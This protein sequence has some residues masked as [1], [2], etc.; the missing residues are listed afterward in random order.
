VRV[1]KNL[2]IHNFL[3]GCLNFLV[4]VHIALISG[5]ASSKLETMDVS[6][7]TT[8]DREP[9]FSTLDTSF[10]ELKPLM[11]IY[12]S[13]NGKSYIWFTLSPLGIY[14]S[15]ERSMIIANRLEKYRKQKMTEVAW[16]R[17]GKQRL[18]C[19]YTKTK[20][21]DCQILVTL[22]PNVE[23]KE[24]LNLLRCKLETPDDNSCVAPIRS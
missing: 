22:P 8:T 2:L 18:I 16:G 20:P 17:L 5:C 14:S 6:E 9:K 24:V 19:V 11:V 13:N 15:D 10:G 7:Y 21:S 23:T 12:T 3:K 1:Q 4:A